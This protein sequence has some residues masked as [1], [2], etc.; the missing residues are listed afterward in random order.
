MICALATLSLLAFFAK[1]CY[2]AMI[3][4]LIQDFKTTMGIID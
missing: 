4:C 3:D 1:W 2:D